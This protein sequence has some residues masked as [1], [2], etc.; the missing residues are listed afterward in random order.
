M[1]KLEI[2][3]THSRLNLKLNCHVA[4]GDGE[5][6]FSS[7]NVRPTWMIFSKSTL[8]LNSWYW[9]SV[10]LLKSPIGRATTP[11]NSVSC[12]TESNTLLLQCQQVYLLT[13]MDRATLP[14]A[15][16][17]IS[18]CSQLPKNERW[19]IANC[20]IDQEMSVIS[21]FE[22]TMLKLHLVDLLSIH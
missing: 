15:K 8:H 10:L 11:G 3:N 9:Y 5:C 16:S 17:T 6:P 7:R 20:Y 2:R 21:T 18:L 14:H 22:L 13:P 4:T 1:R 19:S 12:P